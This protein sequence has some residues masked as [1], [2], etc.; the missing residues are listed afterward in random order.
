VRTG[1]AKQLSFE[2]LTPPAT[3]LGNAGVDRVAVFA[4]SLLALAI[5][6]P[7]LG[8]DLWID[9]IGTFTHFVKPPLSQ[10]FSNYHA[11]SHILYSVLAHL[12]VGL[13][14]ETSLA[15]RLPALLFGVATVPALYYLG[16]VVTSRIEALSAT[17]LL[18]VSY[19][20]AYFSQSA[21]GY[22]GYL[23]FS[24]LST[25]FLFRALSDNRVRYWV[26]F[27][28]TSA[29]NIYIHLNGVFFLAGQ[30]GGVLMPYALPA[31]QSVKEWRLL[32]RL[33]LCLG[34]IVLL[35]GILYAPAVPSAF[36]F[37][38]TADRNV[39]WPLS[40]ALFKVIVRDVAPGVIGLVA[41]S[42]GL[43]VGV[44]GLVSMARTVPLL[45]Y[46]AFLPLLVGLSFVLAMR[47]G[48]YPRFFLILLPFGLLFAV[49]GL[50]IVA[51]R[52][53]RQIVRTPGS[54]FFSQAAFGVLVLCA[55]VAA[56]S[57]LPR[58]YTLPKQDYTG[59]LAFVGSKRAPDDLVAAAYIADTGV[60]FYDPTVLSARTRD[61]LDRIF[62]RGA[63]IW[64]LGTF[65]ADMRLREPALASLIEA[66][67]GEVRRFPGIVGDG[68]VV[69]WK[70]VEPL[71]PSNKVDK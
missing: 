28:F 22:T 30:I 69:V 60:R 55:T 65:V 52:G 31:A 11:N 62:A 3:E 42:L 59:A 16:R 47:V 64:L 68:T 2:V 67:F 33:L 19:H 56:A 51:D 32:R 6:I 20:H 4:L 25:A 12:S 18:T 44:V 48:T 45:V 40:P 24:I 15:L 34:A 9:E 17:L 54:E 21:R 27:V 63:P 61:D 35:V 29:A 37:F 57:G 38:A 26:G 10:I 41:G 36:T 53:V 39:G 7:G 13:L 43:L 14:G 1:V 66:H 46:V 49:R 23:F 70:S 8:G 5:R 58:L 50:R 71:P